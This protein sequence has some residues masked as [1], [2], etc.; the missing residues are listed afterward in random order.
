MSKKYRFI[1]EVESNMR[2]D[3]TMDELEWTIKKNQHLKLVN[4]VPEILKELL[5]K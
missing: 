4:I 1:I 3:D 2:M 5:R